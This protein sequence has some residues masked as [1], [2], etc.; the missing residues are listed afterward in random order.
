ML[1]RTGAAVLITAAALLSGASIVSCGSETKSTTAA[2]TTSPSTTTSTHPTTTTS[3]AGVAIVNTWKEPGSVSPSSLPLGDNKEATSPTSDQIYVCRTGD[4]NGPGSKVDGPWIHG[5][6]WDAT[7]KV[8]IAGS[9]SWPTASFTM[10]EDGTNRVFVTNDL[11]TGYQTGTFPIASSD[12]AYKYDSNPNKIIQQ[13]ATTVTVPITPTASATPNCTPGTVGI[14]LNGV[15][16]FDALDATGRDAVAHE[17]Q[18]LCQGHPQDAGRYHYHEI[19]S[20]IRDHA[21]GPSTV[22]GY[23]F[24]GTP[25]SSSTTQRGTCR[26]TPTWTRATVARRQC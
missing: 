10:K 5:T 3:V 4:P 23:A 14:L 11:P 2:S 1:T 24:D 8:V 18:D 12:P 26:T 6:T 25:S 13:S 20:C 17:E 16:L 7:A 19:P 21:T 9:V 15:F 22:V